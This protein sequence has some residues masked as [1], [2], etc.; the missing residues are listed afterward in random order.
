VIKDGKVHSLNLRTFEFER[1][2]YFNDWESNT[3]IAADNGHQGLVS[4]QGDVIIGFENDQVHVAYEGTPNAFVIVAKNGKDGIFDMAGKQLVAPNYPTLYEL[5][6]G[7][8]HYFA[9]GKNNVKMAL[10][11]WDKEKNTI[12]NLTEAIYKTINCY[13]KVE[14]G[15]SAT[16]LEGEAINIKPDGTISK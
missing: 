14:A 15:F 12:V 3:S 7:D 10:V 9:M 16:T 13:G 6:F 4:P 8:K 2:P 1:A 11:Y 5:C